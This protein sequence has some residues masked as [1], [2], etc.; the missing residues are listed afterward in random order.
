M[1]TT[2]PDSALYGVD[3]QINKVYK[4]AFDGNGRFS[5]LDGFYKVLKRMSYDELLADSIDLVTMLYALEAVGLT[6][7][8]YKA[9]Q[10]LTVTDS[11]RGLVNADFFHTTDFLKLEQVDNEEAVDPIITYMP[12]AFLASVPEGSVGKY[13][14]VTLTTS[15]GAWADPTQLVP[16]KQIIRDRLEAEFGV[17]DDPLL[18]AYDYEWK[19]EAEYAVEVAARKLKSCTVTEGFTPAV[20]TSAQSFTLAERIFSDNYVVFH[21]SAAGVETVLTSTQAHA[22]DVEV[23]QV[24]DRTMLQ[25]VPDS[26]FVLATG[27]T[28]VIKY[29]PLATKI[30]SSNYSVG[31]DYV[32]AQELTNEVVNLKAQITAL[33]L[34]ITTNGLGS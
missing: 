19:T 6:V 1:A 15:L 10:C 31:N 33:K 5:G 18:M 23:N 30:N 24:Y 9:D 8:E 12:I 7:A 22:G 17:V 14:V 2:W 26:S 4:F 29:Q 11:A 3:V 21:V 16:I 27:D 34:I 32:R 20:S 28:I 25:I 13:A